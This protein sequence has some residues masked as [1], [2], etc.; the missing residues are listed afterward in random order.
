MSIVVLKWKESGKV[1]VKISD[2]GEFGGID[3]KNFQDQCFEI[4]LLYC[5][6]KV[7]FTKIG[8]YKLRN[9]Q[10]AW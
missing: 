6:I 1:F 5:S 4:K 10:K 3:C 7:N 9:F 8:L 2:G